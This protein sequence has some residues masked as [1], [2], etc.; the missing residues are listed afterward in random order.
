MGLVLR[1][2]KQGPPVVDFLRAS[3]WRGAGKPWLLIALFSAG[4]LLMMP[5]LFKSLKRRISL[6]ANAFPIP[7][8]KPPKVRKGRANRPFTPLSDYSTAQFGNSLRGPLSRGG[9][10]VLCHA[11]TSQRAMHGFSYCALAIW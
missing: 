9:C 11:Q 10:A 7:M 5:Q 4:R 3:G 1:P 8:A 2:P 6:T